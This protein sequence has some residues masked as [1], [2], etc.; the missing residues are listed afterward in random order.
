MCSRDE[1]DGDGSV[2]HTVG[3]D[4]RRYKCKTLRELQKIHSKTP[5]HGLHPGNQSVFC[6]I[7]QCYADFENSSALVFITLFY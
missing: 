4:I 7:F 6:K 5:V 3:K 1:I 2:G